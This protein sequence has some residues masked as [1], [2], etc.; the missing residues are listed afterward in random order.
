MVDRPSHAVKGLVMT[1]S[2]NRSLLAA[3]RPYFEAGPLGAL[4][5]GM[6]SGLPYTMIA[7]TL[8]TRLAEAEI[9]K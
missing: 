1:A 6:A 2:A 8:T 4:A 3:I 9:E 5:L 7:A